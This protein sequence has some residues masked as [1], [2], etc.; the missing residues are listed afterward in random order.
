[1]PLKSPP[2]VNCLIREHGTRD[3][4]AICRA[5]GIAVFIV[6]LADLRGFFICE[7]GVDMIFISSSLSRLVATYVCAHELA[8]YLYDKG[9][10]RLF[11]DTY[12]FMVPGKYE[13]RADKFA[14]H[15]LWGE[16]PLYDECR[17]SNYEIAA[18]LN[19]P[20]GLVD[21]RLIDLGI[22]Y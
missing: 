16:L 10:S 20:V 19:I 9:L 14:A 22:F 12:T 17:L 8:H 21:S 6:P 18:C 13:T 7:D 11:L 4:F 15:L 2:E 1:M 5:L 3:P